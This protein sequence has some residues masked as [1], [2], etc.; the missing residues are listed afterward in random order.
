MGVGPEQAEVRQLVRRHAMYAMMSGM[1]SLRPVV[2]KR[3][4][5]PRS[6]PIHAMV[7]LNTGNPVVKMH[8]KVAGSCPRTRQPVAGNVGTPDSCKK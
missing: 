8:P 1:V 4:T 6:P 3:L 5:A 7:E 2:L